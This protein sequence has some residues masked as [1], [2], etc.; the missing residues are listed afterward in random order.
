MADQLK[1]TVPIAL[2]TGSAGGIGQAI[3]K[4]LI[5][6]GFFVI[7][8]YFSNT[9][10]TQN[11]R[12]KMEK[13]TSN[14]LFLQADLRIE[15]E[16]NQMFQTIREKFKKIDVLINNAAIIN[17][18][19]ESLETISSEEMHNMINTNF[20][21]SFF[22]TKKSLILLKKSSRGRVIFIN[23]A[24]SFVGSNREFGYVT[25]KAANVGVVKALTLELAPWNICVNAVVP[26]S[27]DTE[28]NPFKGEAL[29][30]KL[31]KI[32]LGRLGK[33]SEVAYLVSFLS[34]LKSAYIT[35]QHIHINGGRFFS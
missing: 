29:Q 18:K 33:P 19:D 9:K 1:N 10:K 32:P 23:S 4:E 2:V 24:S 5:T 21:G 34:S 6:E 25:S 15:I 27:I 3:V 7:A 35:G 13:V 22:V 30:R 12:Q 17:S 16:V 26:A 31:N 11:F 8:H 20:F 28:M 14:I